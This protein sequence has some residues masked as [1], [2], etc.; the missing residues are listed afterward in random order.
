MKVEDELT[1]CRGS[2]SFLLRIQFQQHASWQGTIH[3]LDGHKKKPFRSLLELIL[4]INEAL[5]MNSE[6]EEISRTWKE[7]ESHS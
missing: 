1:S 2:Q 3:W 5:Q 4:L 7:K 6:N